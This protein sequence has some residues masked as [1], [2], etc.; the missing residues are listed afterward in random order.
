MKMRRLLTFLFVLFAVMGQGMAQ[1]SFGHAEKINKGWSFLRIDAAWNIKEQDAM[2]EKD[3]DDSKWRKVDLPHDW[4]VE[5]PMSPDKGSCQGYLPGGV[6][7]YRLHLKMDNG[8]VSS[9]SSRFIYFEGV[10]NYSEV[11]LNGKLLGKRPS[12]FASFLYDMTPYLED[13]DNVVAVRVDHGQEFDSR[14]Y[15]GSGI[16][17]N[18]WMVTAPKVHLAQW[19]TA[20][21]LTRINT[22]QAELEVDVE[23][24]D[25]SST[26]SSQ[27][28]TAIVQLYDKEKKQ[29]LTICPSSARLARPTSRN[30]PPLSVTALSR[31]LSTRVRLPNPCATR[32]RSRLCSRTPTVHPTF[33]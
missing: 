25:D 27:R 18:V 21:R 4:G 3:F 10:Y 5:L 23:T 16:Y 1:V 33:P 17:R 20:Y 9:Q 29:W 7:W 26:K 8:T 22:K 19:G 24:T 13:G 12:G 6:A 28:V 2:K 31:Y 11:Y 32:P 15:T 30:S 14:W